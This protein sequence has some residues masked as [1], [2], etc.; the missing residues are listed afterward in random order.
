MTLVLSVLSQ[1]KINV[2]FVTIFAILVSV[3]PTN[4]VTGEEIM[5]S[6]TILM[7]AYQNA[8]MDTQMSTKSANYATATA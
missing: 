8:Q 4:S 5:E 6:Y 1:M 3:Q 7:N 2:N